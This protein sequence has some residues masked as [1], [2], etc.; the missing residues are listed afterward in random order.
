MTLEEP[1][2]PHPQNQKQNLATAGTE[3]PT[4]RLRRPSWNRKLTTPTSM[5][6]PEGPADGSL[7][8]RD[9]NPCMGTAGPSQDL[10]SP[11]ARRRALLRE[12]EAQVQAAYGQVRDTDW[13]LLRDPK[14]QL[15]IKHS[16]NQ[17]HIHSGD[18]S[19]QEKL[20]TPSA[21]SVDTEGSVPRAGPSCIVS[22]SE[23]IQGLDRGAQEL[24][25]GPR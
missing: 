14:S 11:T 7:P 22:S 9:S 23:W 2:S 10:A 24:Q 6:L 17:V 15:A 18:H 13:D 20:G 25:A 5:A 12:L 21:N 16:Q 1:G 19:G 8:E 3:P 4:Y